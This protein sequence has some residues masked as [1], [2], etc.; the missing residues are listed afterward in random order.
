MCYASFWGPEIKVE[1]HNAVLE[2]PFGTQRAVFAISPLQC[3]PH[4]GP[5]L[6]I[7]INVL[8]LRTYTFWDSR[9]KGAKQN[10]KF[11]RV[12][13]RLFHTRYHGSK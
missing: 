10:E 4:K 13:N 9:E 12:I 8:I 5:C 2:L 1:S 7:I 6:L 3:F 11:R